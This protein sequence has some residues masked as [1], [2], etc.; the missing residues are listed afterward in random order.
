MARL[1]GMKLR[2]RWGLEARAIHGRE[3]QARLR[4]GEAIGLLRAP[5]PVAPLGGPAFGNDPRAGAER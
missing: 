5:Q 1:A 3:H 2:E 4:L